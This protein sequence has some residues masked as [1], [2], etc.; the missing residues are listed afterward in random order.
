VAGDLRPRQGGDVGWRG[1]TISMLWRNSI[2]PL[3]RTARKGAGGGNLAPALPSRTIQR[4]PHLLLAVC[5]LCQWH[6]ERDPFLDLIEIREDLAHNR[7]V[8]AIATLRHIDLR[9]AFEVYRQTGLTIPLSVPA[10]SRATLNVLRDLD[11]GEWS[12][13]PN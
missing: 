11:T 4:R 13:I 5:Q 1:S 8:L 6:L 12:E 2:P 10:D 7:F 3:S 9:H